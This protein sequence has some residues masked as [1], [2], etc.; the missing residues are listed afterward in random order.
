M[1]NKQ[2]KVLVIGGRD[3]QVKGLNELGVFYT[4]FQTKDELTPYQLE[5]ADELYII[6][7]QDIDKTLEQAAMF[8]KARCYDAVLG[9]REF[10]QLTAAKIAE[11]FSL[12]SNCKS[13]AVMVTR[14]KLLMRKSM[15]SRGIN[16]V[17]YAEISTH[18]ELVGFLETIGKPLI[19]KPLDGTG[20]QGVIKVTQHNAYEAYTY[21]RSFTEHHLLAEEY[22]DGQEFSVES[23][24]LGGKHQILAITE[25]LTT[26]APYFVEVGHNQPA[27][28]AESDEALIIASVKE[29]LD[30][31]GHDTG[32]CHTEVKLNNHN[33]FII[34]T[35]TRN[36]G[37]NIWEMTRLTTGVD[38][39][40]YTICHL[41]NLKIPVADPECNGVAIR[42]VLPSASLVNEVC[43]VEQ[44]L[45]Q[46]GVKRV[47]IT[48]KPGTELGSLQ[49]SFNRAGYVMAFGD[50]SRDAADK[51]EQA[52]NYITVV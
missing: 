52:L 15:E 27:E 34:E 6:N 49:S 22:I 43:G 37:D 17:A 7:Y 4:L 26:G 47:E 36:G 13:D 25:K 1:K 45:Q 18:S 41:L 29:L 38:Y 44:A 48:A 42:F 21:A 19:L 32:P 12:P 39:F 20:S 28:L 8:H 31:I 30:V 46:Q 11:T 35:H 14:D 50:S 40:K 24:S 2:L 16:N 23:V 3:F 5:H 51:A 9:Y 33:A 10:A